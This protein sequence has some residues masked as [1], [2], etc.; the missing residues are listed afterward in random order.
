MLSYLDDGVIKIGVDLSEGGT[1]AYLSLAR[2]GSNLIDASSS[3]RLVQSSY[4]AGPQPLGNPSPPW[5]NTPWNPVAAGDRYGHASRVVTHRN[6]G[7]TIYIRSVPM[8][9]AL[10]DIPCNCTFEMWISLHGRVVHVFNRLLNRRVDRRQ[11]PAF[12]QELPATYAV[13]SLSR[14]VTYSGSAPFT[15]DRLTVV[16]DGCAPV[17][18]FPATEHWTA[19]V[20]SRGFGLGVVNRATWR[21]VGGVFCSSMGSS[22][23]G[24]TG[25]ETNYVA[26][27]EKEILDHNITYMYAYDV[28]VGSIRQIRMLATAGARDRAPVYRFQHDRQHWW[29]EDASDHGWPIR[30]ELH[31]RLGQ[32]AEL[33]GPKQLW[34]AAAMP[35]IN[36][37]AA[38]RTAGT[39]AY[40][41][42]NVPEQGFSP[43]RRVDF[44]II[45]D[46]KMRT[47]KVDLAASSAYRGAITGL[48]LDPPAPGRNR[49][50]VE[51]ACI[52]STPC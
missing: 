10:D 27:T 42:W 51:V 1:I 39:V 18:Q 19:L 38:F 25:I 33:V 7:K 32:R 2:N 21:M 41:Y 40:L 22:G 35:R 6:D 8:Q 13:P 36:V 23:G 48:R 17:R 44:S 50:L 43:S 31:V 49:R 4:Y 52:S 14:I 3:G 37:R 20:D 34:Q 29:Y 16:A 45:P 46:G 26:P 15:G 28:I 5:Q 12:P 9:W 47:Y 11:Y 30:G 24:Q